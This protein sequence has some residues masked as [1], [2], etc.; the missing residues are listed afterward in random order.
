M[1]FN[2]NIIENVMEYRLLMLFISLIFEYLGTKT[3]RNVFERE[4]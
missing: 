1:F 3:K 4:I 2:E